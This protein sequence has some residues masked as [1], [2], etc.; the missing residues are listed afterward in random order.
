MK[1]RMTTLEFH[2]GNCFILVKFLNHT[3]INIY[4]H[5]III[6]HNVFSSFLLL[7]FYVSPSKLISNHYVGGAFVLRISPYHD[8]CH[9][10]GVTPHGRIKRNFKTSP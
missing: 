6:I 1:F 5:I 4:I 10:N 7:I 2:H 8:Q 9:V 3:N